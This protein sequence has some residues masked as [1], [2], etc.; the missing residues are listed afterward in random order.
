MPELDNVAAISAAINTAQAKYAMLLGLR[1]DND[2][3]H[4]EGIVT[5]ETAER[6]FNDAERKAVVARDK[7]AG[8]NA[9]KRD[10]VFEQVANTIT[11]W[12]EK[13]AAAEIELNEYLAE[14]EGTL[15]VS[16]DFAVR[17]ATS[18]G[19]TRL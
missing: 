3:N 5:R 8:V 10:Q 19:R 15:G 7:A 16:L 1:R 9:E 13:V 17:P 6:V 12:S 14:M 18:G 11:E 2:V 4:Q